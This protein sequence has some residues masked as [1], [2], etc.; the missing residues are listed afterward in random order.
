MSIAGKSSHTLPL[1]SDGSEVV[2]RGLIERPRNA[3]AKDVNDLLRAAATAAIRE[4]NM[5]WKTPVT[6]REISLCYHSCAHAKIDQ[7][8][9]G[10]MLPSWSM[11]K[12]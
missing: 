10:E 4:G 7:S 2:L 11:K 6:L 9:F 12:L 3:G 5:G 1:L 8:L